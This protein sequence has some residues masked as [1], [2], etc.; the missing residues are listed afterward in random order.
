MEITWD[1]GAIITSNPSTLSFNVYLDDLSGNQPAKVFDSATK[2]LTNILTLTNLTAGNSYLVT[3]TAVNEIGESPPSIPLT[4]YAGTVPSKIRKLVWEDSTTTSITV[5]WEAPSSNGHLSL[6]K[7]TLYIDEGRTGSPTQTIQITDTFVRTYTSTGMTTGQLVD[8]QVT[9]T[10][11]NGESELSDVLTLYVAA[12]PSAPAAPVEQSIF[13]D[14]YSSELMS[15]T[16]GWSEPA[17]NGAPITGYK[18]F[19][20]EMSQAYQLVFDGSNRADIQSYTV[21]NGVKK[22]LSYHFKIVAINNVGESAFSAVLTSFIATVPSAPL[23]FIY[24]DS[25]PS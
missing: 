25:Q 3:V 14:D 8:F 15:I 5:R 13:T 7:F 21:V 24:T 16:V 12:K 6:Q 17:G 10:N 20:A 19:M 22:T 18:L 9:S 11:P 2:A 1:D 4:I 23:G